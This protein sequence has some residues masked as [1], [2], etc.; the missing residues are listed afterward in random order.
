MEAESVDRLSLSDI[1]EANKEEDKED[2]CSVLVL[3]FEHAIVRRKKFIKKCF[4]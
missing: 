2:V 3:S 1:E 4:F